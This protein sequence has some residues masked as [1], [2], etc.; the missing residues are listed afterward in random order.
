MH[1]RYAQRDN[2]NAEELQSIALRYAMAS[3]S[4]NPALVHDPVPCTFTLRYT[5]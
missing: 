2:L 1:E 5:A 4:E 3:E